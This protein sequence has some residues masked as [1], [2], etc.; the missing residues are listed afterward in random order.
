MSGMIHL[1]QKATATKRECLV[2][3]FKNESMEITN[4]T[5]LED[6]GLCE[7]CWWISYESAICFLLND[8]RYLQRKE[9]HSL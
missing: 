5:E 9:K 8:S 7:S 4:K 3:V 6:I 1:A 2:W